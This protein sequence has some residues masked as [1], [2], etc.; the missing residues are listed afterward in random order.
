VR[1]SGQSPD[2]EDFT[3][4]ETLIAKPNCDLL[5]RI[6]RGWQEGLLFMA[7]RKIENKN[8][9]GHESGRVKFRYADSERYVDLDMENANAEVADGIKSLA[10][11]LSGR[12]ITAPPRALAAPKTKTAAAAVVDQEEIQFP[13]D[14]ETEENA[15]AVEPVSEAESDDNRTDKPKRIRKL[16]K[17]IFL[18]SLKLSEAKV[19]LVDFMAQKNPATMMDKYAVVA[20]WLKEQFGIEEISIDHIFSAFKRL[21]QDSK[22]PTDVEKPLQNLTYNRHWFEKG[23]AEN[24]F[25]IVWLGE[26]SVCKM[27]T[28]T[29]AK[30]S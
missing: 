15:V 24:T 4:R 5:T 12:T 8:S 26:D 13:P 11:A 3:F 17:P 14:V 22:L 19:P 20:V 18:N 2:S 25:A 1:A 28:A 6:T 27:G 29:A 16:R 30:A 9:N 21:G 10:N 7:V 23:K